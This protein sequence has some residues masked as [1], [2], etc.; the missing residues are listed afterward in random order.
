MA[1]VL[2][3]LSIIASTATA[4]T[5]TP[6]SVKTAPTPQSSNEV[7]QAAQRF[8]NRVFVGYVL[9]LLLTVFG[10]YW[11]WSSGNKVQDAVQADAS[12]RIE[13]AKKGAA[14]AT[15]TASEANVRAGN[16]EHDNLILRSQVATL[17]TDAAQA[18]KDVAS[19]QKAAADAKA[20]QQKVEI[21]L[22]K[23]QERAATAEKD[24][25]NLRRATEPRHFSPE[26]EATLI[27]LLS[28]EPKGPVIIE[29]L[30]GDEPMAFAQQIDRILTAARWLEGRGK[31]DTFTIGGGGPVGAFINV[32]DANNVPPYATH[33]QQAFFTVGFQLIGEPAPNQQQPVKIFIGRRPSAN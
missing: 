19:L 10:T 24:L 8:H 12:A 3:L 21:E 25:A 17:E 6:S 13:E 30:S 7:I 18:Q 31:I 14:I 32:R 22:A 20:A 4:T 16:L 23:Q 1:F 27:E 11:V 15:Q 26:Q 33:I 28:G 9:L 29:S 5:P 2:L